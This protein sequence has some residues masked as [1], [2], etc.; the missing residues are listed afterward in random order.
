[1][2]SP[3]CPPG[4]CLEKHPPAEPG[5]CAVPGLLPMCCLSEGPRGHWLSRLRPWERS[6][7]TPSLSGR[8]GVWAAARSCLESN[9]GG[10]LPYTTEVQLLCFSLPCQLPDSVDTPRHPPRTEPGR[11]GWEGVYEKRETQV[12]CSKPFGS[13]CGAWLGRIGHKRNC[14][15]QVWRNGIPL[16]ALR[17]SQPAVRSGS[18]RDE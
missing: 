15:P 5:L 2:E 13:E 4:C 9:P 12:L 17:G 16:L 10:G 3:I 7:S 1:M 8:D 6:R 18:L 11:G 14:T